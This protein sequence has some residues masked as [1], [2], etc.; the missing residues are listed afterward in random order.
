MDRS[1]ANRRRP[2]SR[3]VAQYWRRI[4]DGALSSIYLKYALSDRR[5][6]LLSVSGCLIDRHVTGAT[7]DDLQRPWI[8]FPARSSLRDPANRN[9]WVRAPHPTRLLMV[10]ARCRREAT[11]RAGLRRGHPPRSSPI[12]IGR[13]RVISKGF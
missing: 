5:I 12:G 10:V 4:L 6:S 11:P 7:S 8:P 3:S 1:R 9:V 2:P 13:P